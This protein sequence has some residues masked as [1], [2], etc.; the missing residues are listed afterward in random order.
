MPKNVQFRDVRRGQKK[1][2]R[3]QRRVPKARLN[4]WVPRHTPRKIWSRLVG[5]PLKVR[6]A[7]I[8][9]VQASR[10]RRKRRIAS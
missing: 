5:V 3:Q 7:R 8:E 2:G 10:Q 4:N 9:R 6:Q 1:E